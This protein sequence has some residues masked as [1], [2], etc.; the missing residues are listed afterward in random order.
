MIAGANH[1]CNQENLISQGKAC[2]A[3]SALLNTLESNGA[4]MLFASLA[5][6][7][8]IWSGMMVRVKGNENQKRVR[9]AARDPVIK[10]VFWTYMNSLMLLPA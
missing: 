2:G 3:L 5:W 9:R 6:T 1:R 4:Y 8:E 7:L 10:M